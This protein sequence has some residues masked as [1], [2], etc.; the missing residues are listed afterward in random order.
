MSGRYIAGRFFFGWIAQR[1][2]TVLIS[3]I[4]RVGCF[5]FFFVLIDQAQEGRL[6]HLADRLQRQGC[7]LVV[8]FDVGVQPVHHVEVRIG[9]QLFQGSVSNL[10]ADFGSDK[11]REI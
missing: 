1:G 2:L 11:A 9:E 10:A 8:I 3:L 5:F 4:E 7:G 6:R